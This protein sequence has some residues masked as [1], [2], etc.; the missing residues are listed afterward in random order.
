MDSSF[1]S[2]IHFKYLSKLDD[3]PGTIKR[4]N[5]QDQIPAFSV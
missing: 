2:L 3:L 5:K 4:A 1:H